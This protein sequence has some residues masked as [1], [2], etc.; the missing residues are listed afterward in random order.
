DLPLADVPAL[1]R[2]SGG[3]TGLKQGLFPVVDAHQRL[4]GV[5]TRTDL[6]EA[7]D[8]GIAPDDPRT[9]ASIAQAAPQVVYPDEPLRVVMERMATTGLTRFPVVARDDPH[10]LV[11]L[12]TMSDLLR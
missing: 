1:S 2:Q 10:R 3:A 9:L 12:I 4:V 7:L 6:H 11:G 5:V 8:R